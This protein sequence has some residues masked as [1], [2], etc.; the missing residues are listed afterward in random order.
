VRI[1]SFHLFPESQFQRL[2]IQES[3][4]DPTYSRESTAQDDGRG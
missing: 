4:P 3:R 2:K 1:S